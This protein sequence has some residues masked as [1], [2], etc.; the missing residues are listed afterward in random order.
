[1]TNVQTFYIPGLATVK[2]DI[3]D[4]GVPL[5]EI[6]LDPEHLSD[7]NDLGDKQRKDFQKLED[8]AKQTAGPDNVYL[9]CDHVGAVDNAA[10]AKFMEYMTHYDHTGDNVPDCDHVIAAIEEAMWKSHDT[11]EEF[12]RP[13]GGW[14]VKLVMSIM[15]PAPDRHIIYS[16]GRLKER[17]R[18]VHYLA[19]LP[20]L[21]LVFGLVQVQIHFVP[22]MKHSVISGFITGAEMLGAPAWAAIAI[23]VALVVFVVRRSKHLPGK[24]SSIHTYGLLNKA[25]ISEEQAFREGSESW[26]LGQRINS[27]LAFGAIHM[28]NLF[29]PLATILPLAIGGGMFMW[30]YLRTYRSTRS[31]RAAV[32]E[33]SL[34]HRVYNKLALTVLVMVIVGLLGVSLLAA[35]G[36]SLMIV[37]AFSLLGAVVTRR[38]NSRP[39][40]APEPDK[41]E[42][43]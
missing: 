7:L 38:V 2:L 14:F 42:A 6:V 13:S 33:A 5:L 23:F 41:I 22:L 30:V 21:L 32:L 43:V 26:T 35:F 10:L 18:K 24:N 20:L 12:H 34:W 25:A 39:D 3:N 15:P 4:P 11:P 16:F 29:Y 1:M 19:A 31:R 27:C 8:I 9:R 37:A 28:V 36:V 40:P 17:Y